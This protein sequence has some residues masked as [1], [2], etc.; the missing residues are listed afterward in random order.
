MLVEYKIYTNVKYKTETTVEIFKY[1]CLLPC[2]WAI[3]CLYS[4]IYI[5]IL[6]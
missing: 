4:D 6:V 2:L 3:F 5:K 1:V